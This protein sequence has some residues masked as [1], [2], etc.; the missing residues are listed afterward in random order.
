MN[1]IAGFIL[2]N[3]R[4]L[5]LIY[6][7]GAAVVFVGVLLFFW[8]VCRLEEKERELCRYE[9]EASGRM[10]AIV[11]L[12]IAIPCALIWCVIPLI[13]FAV[14]IYYEVTERFPQIMGN[15]A[16]DFDDEEKE[17]IQ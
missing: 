2:T 7:I 5:A 13:I 9:D 4:M 10:T 3:W 16:D 11:S 15:M 8:W 14:W 12:L 1:K 17:E 6:V